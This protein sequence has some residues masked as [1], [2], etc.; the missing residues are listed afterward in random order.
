MKTALIRRQLT[1]Q[2]RYSD[3]ARIAKTKSMEVINRS[4][5]VDNKLF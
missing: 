2:R 4:Y 1:Q 5:F 3:L